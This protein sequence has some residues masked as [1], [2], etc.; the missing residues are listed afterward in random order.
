MQPSYL[1]V[2]PSEN[3]ADSP[4]C[5]CVWEGRGKKKKIMFWFTASLHT[6]TP[7][8]HVER[9]DWLHGGFL[10]IS[11][12]WLWPLEQFLSLSNRASPCVKTTVN[13]SGGNHQGVLG[14]GVGVGGDGQPEQEEGKKRKKR[15]AASV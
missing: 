14:R 6:V 1:Q 5:V 7:S 15:I 2:E 13:G 9:L 8:E 12:H 11:L 3:T 10:S 4:N